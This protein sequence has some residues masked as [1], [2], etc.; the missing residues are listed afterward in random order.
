MLGTHVVA[1]ALARGRRV[2]A[3]LLPEE[4]A[5]AF[6]TRVRDLATFLGW[7]A[8]HAALEV[9][10]GRF[11]DAGL[12]PGLLGTC[13]EVVHCAGQVAG[14]DAA[15]HRAANVGLVEALAGSAGWTPEHRLVHVSS[16]AAQGPGEDLEPV[17]EDAPPRPRGLYGTTKRAGEEALLAAGLPARVVIARPCSILGPLDRNFFDVFRAGRDHGVYVRFGTPDKWFQLVYAPDLA[18][19]LLDL[20]DAAGRGEPFPDTLHVAPPDA[21]VHAA[22]AAAVGQALDRPL[23]D[24][25]VAPWATRVVGWWGWLK[26]RLTG[27][28]VLLCRDK[29]E[30]MLRRYWV[31][32][33]ARLRRVLP[34]A[35]WTPL[36]AACARTHAWYLGAGWYEGRR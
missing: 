21:L 13:R 22:F 23:R 19:V 34:G 33:T 14:D 4:D 7:G 28:P 25:A 20:L 1:A 26:E 16:V 27:E 31:H 24:V 10:A 32:D 29:M 8:D 6:R 17:P 2:H 35:R 5:A 11:R 30:D 9:E 36:T 12:L 18:G 3:L 15:R